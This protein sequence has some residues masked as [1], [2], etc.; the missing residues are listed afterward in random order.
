MLRER[1]V[2]AAML[3]GVGLLSG[4]VRGQELVFWN[5]LDSRDAVLHSRVGPD[6]EFF[7]GDHPANP[8]WTPGVDGNALTIGPGAYQTHLVYKNAVIP[9]IFSVIRPEAGTVQ[10]WLRVYR[11]AIAGLRNDLAAIR[12]ESRLQAV[13]IQVSHQQ[14]IAKAMGVELRGIWAPFS[15]NWYK[16]DLLWDRNGIDGS[17]DTV[18]LYADGV[19][20]GRSTQ[21]LLTSILP[22]LLDVGSGT[23]G[24]LEGAFAVD[25]LKIW[26]GAVVPEPEA[27]LFPFGEGCAG[28][29][30][31]PG[32]ASAGLPTVGAT[33]DLTVTNLPTHPYALGLLAVGAS[34]QVF[35][36]VAL[37]QD[38]G[39]YGAPACRL[40]V[41]RE[42]A[43]VLFGWNGVAERAVGIPSDSGLVGARFFLQALVADAA[44]PLGL[45]VSN[46]YEG[47]IGPAR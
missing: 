33:L 1:S 3:L 44:N 18:R 6:M 45:C 17:A 15:G 19:L 47:R 11:P 23:D 16:I 25:E 30:G 34:N 46:A 26:N 2:A 41:G 20:S 5:T 37:P 29:H 31:V 14:F 24:D 13:L 40:F 35:Q 7:G 22:A 21:P 4:G 12:D 8:A 9:D 43:Y 42:F 10:L 32:L 27:A 39:P 28:T 38:L 36:G